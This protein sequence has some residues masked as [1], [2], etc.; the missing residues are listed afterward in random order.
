MNK[1][2]FLK[3]IAWALDEGCIKSCPAPVG[4]VL[5]GNANT[6]KSSN[7]NKA[8][9]KLENVNP[10]IIKNYFVEMDESIDF[11][12]RDI[13]MFDCHLDGRRFNGDFFLREI[14]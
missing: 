11:C 12:D 10:L 5:N 2:S 1:R 3:C 14:K 7:L 9:K 6:I 8:I 13:K 4:Y